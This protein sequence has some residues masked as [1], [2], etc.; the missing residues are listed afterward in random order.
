ML[1]AVAIAYFAGRRVGEKLLPV[2]QQLT[3]RRGIIQAA[4]FAPDG[5]TIYYA[6]SWDGSPIELFSTR[7]ESPESR[8]VGLPPAG[9]L[10]IAPSGET[11]ISLGCRFPAAFGTIGTLAQVSLSGGAPRELLEEVHEADWSPDGKEL[12]VTRGGPGITSGKARLEFPIGKVLYPSTGWISHPRIS[13]KGDLIAFIDHPPFHDDGAIAV[14]DLA[15][16]KKTLAPGWTSAQGLAW[17]PKGEE[18]WFTATQAGAA[19]AL[20]AVTLSGKQRLVTRVTGALTIQDIGRDGR[21][22]MIH[23]NARMALQAR[24]PGQSE[25]RDLSW[26]DWSLARDISADGKTVLFDETGEGSGGNYGVYVRKTDGS[27]AVRLGDGTARALSPDGRWALTRNLAEM[28][29]VL[30]PTRAGKSI[31][32]EPGSV[33]RLQRAVW[34]SNGKRILFVGAEPG[35]ELRCYVQDIEGGKPRPVTPEG[36]VGFLLSPDGRFV[37]V[38][39]RNQAPLLYPVEGGS[40]RPVSGVAPGE[41]AIRWSSDGRSIFVRQFGDLPARV[42]RVDLSTGRRELWKE[43]MPSDRA[44]VRAISGIWLAADEKSYVY[45][46]NRTLS[47]LYL[48]NGLK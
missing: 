48:V 17:T 41:I 20:R 46:Y 43:I 28:Q 9:I 18:I 14:V 31:T 22:L 35:H 30:L 19:R 7:P 1:A 29:T 26:L 6:A 11:A 3:F 13:P 40:P 44:G 39:D 32:L 34:F 24:A 38:R 10:A 33:T 42:F 36:T 2:F 12:A 23:E 45:S 21:V 5:R 15:G 8:P 37:A 4:R 27:P 47:D 16:K 25:E